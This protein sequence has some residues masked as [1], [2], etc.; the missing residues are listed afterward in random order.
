MQEI[1]HWGSLVLY[2]VSDMCNAL[3]QRKEGIILPLRKSKR[4]VH[5][6]IDFPLVPVKPLQKHWNKQVGL[7]LDICLQINEKEF[8]M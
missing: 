1:P 7:L 5:Q 4:T 3:V 8:L 2:F 6:D